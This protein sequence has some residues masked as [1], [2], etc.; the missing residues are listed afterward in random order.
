MKCSLLFLP[1]ALF[2]CMGC[3]F[4]PTTAMETDVEVATDGEMGSLINDKDSPE[5]IEKKIKEEKVSKKKN[6]K[7]TKDWS[8]IDFNAVE[9]S[10]EGGDDERE[11]D[12]DFEIRYILLY[13]LL[14]QLNLIFFI[15]Y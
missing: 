6:K 11:L 13:H 8:K 4:S 9:K 3:Y 12:H 2:L 7:A 1:I 15:V 5:A 14:Y 10:W